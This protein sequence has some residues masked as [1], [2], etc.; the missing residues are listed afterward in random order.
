M[1]YTTRRSVLR[2]VRRTLPYLFRFAGPWVLVTTTAVVLMALSNYFA[3]A[4]RGGAVAE[5]LRTSLILQAALSILAVLALA[6]ATTYRL[7]GPWIALQ[8]ALESVRDGDLRTGLRL[9]ASDPQAAELHTAF[10]E[11]LVSLRRRIPGEA[12][13]PTSAVP[14]AA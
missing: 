9:R 11:M 13:P 10:E 12:E 6:V 4:T 7:A 2:G 1:T 5:D 8:R 3:F 14:P